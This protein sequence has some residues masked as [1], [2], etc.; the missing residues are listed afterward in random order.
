M[1]TEG[2]RIEGLSY[3]S[4]VRVNCKLVR[5]GRYYNEDKDTPDRQWFREELGKFAPPTDGSYSWKRTPGSRVG[6]FLGYRVL[7]EGNVHAGGGWGEDYEPSTYEPK[8]RF[9]VAYV[10]LSER[11]NPVYVPLTE[12]EVL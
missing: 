2:K 3:G 1:E 9:L 5:K 10:S 12:L 7:T 11:E 8:R 4:A 6:I